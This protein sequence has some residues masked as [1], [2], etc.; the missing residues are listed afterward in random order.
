M[1]RLTGMAAIQPSHGWDQ[2]HIDGKR[3]AD[4]DDDDDAD[5]DGDD[6]DD[7]DDGFYV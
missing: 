1:N 2:E 3:N 5:D 4:D 7:A 6:D